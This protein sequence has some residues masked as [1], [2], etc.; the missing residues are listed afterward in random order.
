MSNILVIDDDEIML[1][2][3]QYILNK[4]GYN[5]VTATDGKEAFELLEYSVYDVV[6]T[7]LRMPRMNGMEVLSKLRGNQLN[8]KLGIIIVSMVTSEQTRADALE[9]GADVFL[10]KPIVV[11]ELRESIKKLIAAGRQ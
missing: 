3:I 6:I 7:D 2:T 8:R 10:N 9:M 5:V 11:E 1:K 4:D